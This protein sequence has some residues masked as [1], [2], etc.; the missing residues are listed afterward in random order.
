[1]YSVQNYDNYNNYLDVIDL[2][3]VARYGRIVPKMKKQPVKKD[4]WY[5]STAQLWSIL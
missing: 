4:V 5:P 2:E 3:G 1:M